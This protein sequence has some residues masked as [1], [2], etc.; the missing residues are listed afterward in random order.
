MDDIK[1][2]DILGDLVEASALSVNRRF[3]GNLHNMG[4]NIIS[5][6]HDPENRFM[7]ANGVMGEVSTAMRDPVFYRWHSFIDSLFK[8]FKNSLEPYTRQQLSFEQVSIESISTELLKDGK[9]R[10]VLLTYWQQSDININGGLDFQPNGDVTFEYSHLQ[11]A[12][13]QYKVLVINNE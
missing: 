1:G 7:E 5:F 3:Y 10:N 2:I 9:I 4:H 13:F 11:H 6:A 8:L 12:P